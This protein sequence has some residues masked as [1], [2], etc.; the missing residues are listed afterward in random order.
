MKTLLKPKH[1]PLLTMVTGLL[2][3]FLRLLIVTAGPDVSGLYQIRT[4]EWI[5]FLTVTVLLMVV[6]ILM[7]RSLKI[8]GTFQENYPASPISATGSLLG[9]VGIL[10]AAV[11]YLRQQ[12]QTLFP[13]LAG[14]TGLLAAAA[15]FSVALARLRGEKPF[16]LSHIA[17]SLHMALR[18]FDTSRIWS[19]ETQAGLFL[20]P[21]MAVACLFLASY[22]LSTFD[23]DMGMRRHSIFW[24]L[25]S[26]HLCITT[27]AD[28]ANSQLTQWTDLAFYGGCAIWLLTNLCCLHPLKEQPPVVPEE[29]E[30]LSAVEA[31]LSEPD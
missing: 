7:T 16:F 14:A 27:L 18:I 28:A 8:S 29:P 10:L 20:V 2:G 26:I 19:N 4:V 22:Y 13:L 12:E 31:F 21:F 5:L 3:F 1:L 30:D 25:C 6:T 23:V 11:P 24:S 17:V 9:A 15:L